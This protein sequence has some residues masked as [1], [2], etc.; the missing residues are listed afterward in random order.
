MLLDG[1][2]SKMSSVEQGVTQSCSLFPRLFSVFGF[3]EGSR[4]GGSRSAAL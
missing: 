1:E 4:R 2:K 3:V